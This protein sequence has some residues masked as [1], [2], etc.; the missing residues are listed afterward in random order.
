MHAPHHFQYLDGWRGLAIFFLL[1]GHFFP[2]PGINFG[3]IGVNLFFV[4]SGLL[5]ARLLFIQQVPIPHFYRRRIA[6]IF[7]AVLVFLVVMVA[8]RLMLG[9]PIAWPEIAAAALFINNYAVGELGANAMPFGHFWSL[10]VEEHSYILLSLLAIACRKQLA[11]AGWL[12][13]VAALTICAIGV[14]YG[15]RFDA[16]TLWRLSMH[17]EAAAFGIFASAALV[18]LLE[19]KKLPRL[20]ALVTIGL[21]LGGIM[22]YW[23]K[24]PQPLKMLGGVTCFAIAVNLLR[25]AP[26]SVHAVLSFGPLRVLGLWSFSIYIWQQPF[27]LLS[28]YHG[29]PA[30]AGLLLAFACGIA[31]FYL[32]EQ[33][34]RSWLNRRW[35]PAPANPDALPAA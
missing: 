2:V 22:L 21:L 35:K 31:S 10:C 14:F 5:M 26:A 28:K 7:P 27:Y 13:P 1:I 3:A 19:G 9:Q 34:A 8:V 4:L 6:R 30:V 23:W 32:V 11:K 17:S 33:P 20:P 12:V 29:L 18:V 24:V 16:A 25:A 15:L